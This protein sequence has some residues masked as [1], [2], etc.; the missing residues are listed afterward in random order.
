[1]A[2]TET[3]YQIVFCSAKNTNIQ[4]NFSKGFLKIPVEIPRKY[5]EIWDSNTKYR[6]GLG[7]F[8]VYQIYGFQLTPLVHIVK[9]RF[10]K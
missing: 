3:K 10:L 7:I 8:L 2:T 1:M 6:F 5:Q 9:L 4:P